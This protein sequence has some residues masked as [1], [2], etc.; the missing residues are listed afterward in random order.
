MLIQI[1]TSSKSKFIGTQCFHLRTK[2][3]QLTISTRKLKLL[4]CHFHQKLMI[5]LFLPEKAFK[6][7]FWDNS[8]PF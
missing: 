6:N 4:F 8:T 3:C 7:L 1:T 2:N 5:K